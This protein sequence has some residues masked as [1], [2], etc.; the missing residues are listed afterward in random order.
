MAVKGIRLE[1]THYVPDLRS[2][3]ISV[4]K[5]IDA[6]HKVIFDGK[7]ATV[8]KADGKV[9]LVANRRG[10]LYYVRETSKK[11]ARTGIASN[12]ERS[13][14]QIW[15]ERF[16]HLNV[17]DLLEM[18]RKNAAPGMNLGCEKTLPPCEICSKGKLT[19]LNFPKSTYRNTEI[20]EIVHADV[21]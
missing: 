9:L 19:A 1:N 15:H 21:R 3:L 4:A 17:K 16:G 5:I 10:D 18:N 7:R 20:L 11:Q 2:N 13:K 12:D 6:G 14:L 8:R